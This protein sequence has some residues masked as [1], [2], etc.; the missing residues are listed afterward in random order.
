[1]T[2][3][4]SYKTIHIFKRPCLHARSLAY[5]CL[6]KQQS[7]NHFIYCRCWI[8]KR[9]LDNAC[10]QVKDIF[11]FKIRWKPYLLNPNTP[12]EGIP[13][14]DHIRFK[15]G[16]AAAKAAYEGTSPLYEAAS[17]VVSIV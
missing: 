16:E 17:S 13:Y 9:K 10:E 6:I 3:I 2:P 5:P 7:N 15:Y 14:V 11:N 1:M 12:E 8:G 4:G